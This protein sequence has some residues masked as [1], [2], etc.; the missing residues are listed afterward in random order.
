MLKI[1]SVSRKVVISIE[2]AAKI[3]RTTLYLVAVKDI[4]SQS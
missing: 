3:T 4:E 1:L 2:Y